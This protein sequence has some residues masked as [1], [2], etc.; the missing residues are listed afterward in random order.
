MMFN[1][2]KLPMVLV[3]VALAGAMCIPVAQAA[4]LGGEDYNDGSGNTPGLTYSQGSI[5]LGEDGD[6]KAWAFGP[7]NWIDTTDVNSGSVFLRALVR[8]E[9]EEAQ[10]GGVSFFTDDQ[11]D[12]IMYFGA[13]TSDTREFFGFH[14]QE[15]GDQAASAVLFD[16][17]TTHLMVGEL[18]IDAGEV[19][20]WIDPPASLTPPAPDLTAPFAMETAGK[21]VGSVRL[22]GGGDPG[23]ITGDEIVVGTT[24]NDVVAVPEPT[25][26]LLFAVGTL[27]LLC[28]RRTR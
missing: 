6:N 15:S 12:E 5:D 17:G 28:W 26:L 21:E 8:R 18:D 3:A 2:R 23:F 14:D 24:W 20:L 22:N 4:S 16:M 27:A 10:W 13:S 7:V 1:S 11:G 19:R 9:R 25:T